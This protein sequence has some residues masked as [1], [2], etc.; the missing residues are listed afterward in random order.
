MYFIINSQLLAMT[1]KFELAI[2]LRSLSHF[3]PCRWKR[4]RKIILKLI[5]NVTQM[6][7]RAIYY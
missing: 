7:K 1:E 6:A 2:E 5:S 4:D 3:F